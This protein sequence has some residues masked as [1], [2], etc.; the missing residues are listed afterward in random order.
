MR[1]APSPRPSRN[2]RPTVGRTPVASCR[3]GK[4]AGDS[5][6]PQTPRHSSLPL[7]HPSSGRIRPDREDL[8][9][10]IGRTS[11][12]AHSDVNDANEKLSSRYVRRA[13]QHQAVE[14]T[15]NLDERLAKFPR[16]AGQPHADAQRRHGDAESWISRAPSPKAAR[17]SSTPS[18]SG[19]TR[20]QRP[21]SSPRREAR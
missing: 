7:D 13:C 21:I 1:L 10:R 12:R 9:R 4:S 16:R 15:Q 2:V 3:H 11:R 17:K 20:F 6:T 8:W 18:T 14:V 19:S 5:T